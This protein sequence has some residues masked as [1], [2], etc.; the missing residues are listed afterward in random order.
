[1]PADDLRHQAAVTSVDVLDDDDDRAEPL[2]Q[3]AED[4]GQ[5][6]DAA[7][8][9]RDG[10]DLER[11]WLSTRLFQPRYS[12]KRLPIDSTVIM[13]RIASEG[14]PTGACRRSV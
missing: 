3:L 8:R 6:V 10:D 2:R 5:G 4:A 1:V 13:R 12:D 11:G 14:R 7:S 9:R